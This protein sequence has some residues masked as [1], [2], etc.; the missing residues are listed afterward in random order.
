M[1]PPQYEPIHPGMTQTFKNRSGEYWTRALSVVVV[2]HLIGLFPLL[3]PKP[4]DAFGFMLMANLIGIVSLLVLSH[5]R[6][7]RF[8]LRIDEGGVHIEDHAGR[9]AFSKRLAEVNEVC[10]AKRGHIL[11][12]PIA[13]ISVL[14]AG[15]PN[16]RYFG[17][18][19]VRGITEDFIHDIND[20][21]VRIKKEHA[22]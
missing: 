3:M 13:W 10:L 5:A 20:S 15:I 22:R 11:N 9:I 12:F 14:E 16:P 1:S 21:L 2:V 6:P 19:S 18:I 17:A 7:R 4:A 8:T